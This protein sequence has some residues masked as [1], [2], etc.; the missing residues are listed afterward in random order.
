MSELFSDQTLIHSVEIE[1]SDDLRL[2]RSM[3]LEL[4]FLLNSYAYC[5]GDV[6]C[7]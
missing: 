1:Y 6:A 2:Q 5:R 3:G 4:N 7:A